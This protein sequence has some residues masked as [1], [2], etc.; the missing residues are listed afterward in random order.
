[1]GILIARAA[2]SANIGTFLAAY[3]LVPG[4]ITGSGGTIAID[5]AGTT[6]A[7]FIGGYTLLAGEALTK[8]DHIIFALFAAI[9]K[10]TFPSSL[11][12]TK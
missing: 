8:A 4:L 7:L 2:I 12:N 1:M 10:I 9:A 11:A 5:E 3:A 6:S